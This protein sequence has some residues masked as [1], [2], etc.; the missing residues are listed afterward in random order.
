MMLFDVCCVLVSG[1]RCAFFVVGC[2]LLMCLILLV[3]ISCR[4]CC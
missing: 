4:R 1:N 2:L 3:I